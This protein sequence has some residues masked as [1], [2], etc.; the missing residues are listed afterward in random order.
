[1]ST[2]ANNCCSRSRHHM[3]FRCSST[4]LIVF[5]EWLPHVLQ[6]LLQLSLVSVTKLLATHL[7]GG[8]EAVESLLQVK[9]V[10]FLKRL[11]SHVGQV[12]TAHLRRKAFNENVCSFYARQTQEPLSLQH[13]LPNHVQMEEASFFLRQGVVQQVPHTYYT[14][15]H[16]Y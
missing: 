7:L 9:L 4:D 13:R 16:F 8:G 6:L 3:G 2:E 14:T 11:G 5:A 12:A 10:F 1:M 15:I